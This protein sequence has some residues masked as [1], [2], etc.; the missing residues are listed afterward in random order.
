MDLKRRICAAGIVLIACV[1]IIMTGIQKRER[2]D[3]ASKAMVYLINGNQGGNGSIFR[4]TE[5]ELVIVTTYHLVKES[6]IIEVCFPNQLTV[7]GNVILVNQE[8]DVGFI[9]VDLSQ[10]SMETRNEI[11]CIFYDDKTYKS[12]KAEDSMEYRYLEWNDGLFLAI[13]RPGSIGHMNWYVPELADYLIYNYCDVEPGM[14]G[15]A[16]VAEDG[17][18]IG[19]MIGGSQNESGALSIQVIEKIYA[20][21]E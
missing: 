18:Y 11:S 5:E 21:I 9:A 19:M 10:I 7:V 6:E 17:S 3:S 14:S 8:H 4:I 13:T 1:C 2:Y 16:A 12:L 20:D 15:C